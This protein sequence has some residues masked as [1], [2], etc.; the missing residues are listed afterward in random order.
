M[1]AQVAADRC[2]REP[3]APE[4][5][6][7]VKRAARDDD[8]TRAHLHGPG[9]HPDGRA[10]LDENA[11]RAHADEHARAR[12]R[13]V[14]EP[15]LGSP[16]LRTERAAE[17]AV[18]ADAVL[19]AAA[20]VSRLRAD[21]PAE[22]LCSALEHAIAPGRR[23]VLLVDVHPL[24]DRVEAARELVGRERGDAVRRPLLSHVVRRPKRG[25]PVHR[26]PAAETP[27]REE[28]ER[29]VL[30]RGR[31]TF[32]VEPMQRVDLLAAE[33]GSLARLE[34]DDV[35]ARRGENARRRSAARAGADDAHVAVE[36]QLAV[37]ALGLERQRARRRARARPDTRATPAPD[38]GSPK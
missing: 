29:L 33:R 15:R 38:P 24:L 18:A 14:G 7:R 19:V 28:V 4:Q 36:A 11:L 17:A 10:S 35:E 22:R 34:H 20:H 5:R 23:A 25:R 12:C 2:V 27:A 32:E 3:G 30:G 16:A 13:R 21:V 8:R 9:V 1:E 31:S 37:H 6:R 26:R